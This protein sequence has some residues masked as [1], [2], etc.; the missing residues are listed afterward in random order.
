MGK[1]GPGKEKFNVLLSF[2]HIFDRWRLR[3]SA[4][5]KAKRTVDRSVQSGAVDGHEET[6]GN[7]VDHSPYL[8]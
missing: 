3:S 4:E 8:R 2:K 1:N 6:K 7:I 5:K